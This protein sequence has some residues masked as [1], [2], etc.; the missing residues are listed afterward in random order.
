MSEQKKLSI[1][2]T[3]DEVNVIL[4]ALSKFPFE[5]VADLINTVR[6]QAIAQVEVPPAVFEG[7]EPEVEQA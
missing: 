7:E 5:Q 2:L 3:V 6:N 4:T 1:E